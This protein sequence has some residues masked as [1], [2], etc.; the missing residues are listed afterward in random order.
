MGAAAHIAEN[1]TVSIALACP[2]C[3]HMEYASFTMAGKRWQCPVCAQWAVVPQDVPTE[4]PVMLPCPGCSSEL[5]VVRQ[6][7]G[8]QV[9]CNACGIVLT[10]SG[11]AQHL[12]LVAEERVA[13]EDEGARV[14]PTIQCKS[15]GAELPLSPANVGKGAICPN[16]C[17]WIADQAPQP[18]VFAG[19]P[20]R[21]A[22][23]HAPARPSVPPPAPRQER[24]C[25]SCGAPLTPGAVFCIACGYNLTTGQRAQGPEVESATPRL[26]SVCGE[27]LAPGQPRCVKCG[28]S[29]RAT[30]LA[31]P[32]PQRRP[33]HWPYAAGALGLLLIF[34]VGGVQCVR[35]L[36]YDY[37]QQF[38][39]LVAECQPIVKFSLA[40]EPPKEPVGKCIEQKVLV[41]EE[42]GRV[43]DGFTDP[44]VRPFLPRKVSEVR[45][46]VFLRK[47]AVKAKTSVSE[48]NADASGGTAKLPEPLVQPQQVYCW[49]CAVDC[50]SKSVVAEDLLVLEAP[51]QQQDVLAMA[52]SGGTGPVAASVANWIQQHTLDAGEARSAASS[53]PAPIPRPVDSAEGKKQDTSTP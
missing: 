32:L 35:V 37:R 11:D 2:K 1:P 8:K 3:G 14:T 43:C 28:I 40:A 49:I 23:R 51:S 19:S 15:C 17:L 6:L 38:R 31:P 16:C 33:A 47:A 45:T 10:V 44:D 30:Q 29:V 12:S 25:P 53:K 26:C 20:G 27:P 5:R 22:A 39:P 21:T 13:R 36:H 41:C 48:W 9:R 50:A 24:P 34:I 7:L 42:D 18:T 52:F 4:T 46:I